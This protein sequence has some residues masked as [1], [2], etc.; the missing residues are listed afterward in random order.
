VSDR[1]TLAV[2]EELLAWPKFANSKALTETLSETL[3]DEGS[4][5]A[6]QATNGKNTQADVAKIAGVV[7]STVSRLWG[8]WRRLG[9]VRDIDNRALHLADPA[10]LGLAP[11][12]PQSQR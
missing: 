6:Y 10:D 4:F 9:L 12:R 7:Q 3:K 2:L 1:D 5:R 11:P 8:Q